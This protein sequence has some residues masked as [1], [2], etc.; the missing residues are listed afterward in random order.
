M[1]LSATHIYEIEQAIF[2][3]NKIKAIKIYREASGSGLASSKAKIEEIA[4]KLIH[5]KPWMFNKH[6]HDLSTGGRS[7]KISKSGLISFFVFDTII[8]AAVAYWFFVYQPSLENI[9]ATKQAINYKQPNLLIAERVEQNKTANIPNQAVSLPKITTKKPAIKISQQ[10]DT[11]IL[12]EHPDKA[13]FFSKINTSDSFIALYQEK[14]SDENYIKRKANYSL[15]RLFDKTLIERKIKTLRSHLALKRKL[16]ANKQAITIP[17]ITNKPLLDGKIEQH[18][19]QNSIALEIG[20]DKDTTLYLQ[21]DGQWLFIACDV[22]SEL[23]DKGYDQFVVY[24]HAGLLPELVNE[25]IHVGRK[26]YTNT[27]RQTTIRWQ[28]DLPNKKQERWKTYPI[29]D[30]GIYK[31]AKGVSAINVNRHYELAVLLDE[32]GIH[33]SIPFTL[34]ALVE[35]DPLNDKNGKYI[36]RQYLGYLGKQKKPYWFIVKP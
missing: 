12:S 9:N 24:F 18:E 3:G 15:N 27:I 2:K 20:G 30:W 31:Y 29:S 11:V 14:L 36:K 22:R 25:R 21:S 19:W 17:L 8:F 1:K 35:T 33:P 7:S 13:D 26:K 10:S 28:G 4:Q 16:P 34:H 5:D 23:T 32:V 6:D